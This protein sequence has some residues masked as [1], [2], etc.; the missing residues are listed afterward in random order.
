MY[1]FGSL[2]RSLKTQ[3]KFNVISMGQKNGD[4]ERAEKTISDNIFFWN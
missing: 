1:Q 2:I 3:K 4:R